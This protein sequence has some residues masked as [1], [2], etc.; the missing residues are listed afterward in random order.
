M[1][2]R[3]GNLAMADEFSF[4]KTTKERD[5]FIK[6]ID[7]LTASLYSA[8]GVSNVKLPEDHYSAEMLSY[9]EKILT[10]SSRL[11]PNVVRETLSGLKK[12]ILGFLVLKI[13]LS[14]EPTSDFYSYLSSFFTE[15]LNHKVVLDCV[16]NPVMGG[17]ITIETKGL[18]KD[19][20]LSKVIDQL[21]SE[22]RDEIGGMVG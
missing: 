19:Y 2:K 5:T 13:T 15:S 4:I 1:Q 12:K 3:K 17:G 8:S 20:S 22:H 6:G 9:F 11:H 14:F 18:Y 7:E 21:F 10:E 16:I